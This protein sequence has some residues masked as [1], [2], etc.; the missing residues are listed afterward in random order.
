MIRDN[1][2]AKLSYDGE[3]S[4]LSRSTYDTLIAGIEKMPDKTD[5]DAP[6]NEPEAETSDKESSEID[7]NKE[8]PW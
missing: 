5:G 3:L 2:K 6:T 1:L 4:K 8:V 7:L